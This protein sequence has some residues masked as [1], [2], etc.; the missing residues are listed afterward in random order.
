M[1]FVECFQLNDF[2]TF[3]LSLGS[4]MSALRSL[5]WGIRTVLMAAWRFAL[6]TSAATDTFS[7]PHFLT[8][9]PSSASTRTC[10]F[11]PSGASHTGGEHRERPKT[12][13]VPYKNCDRQELD[14]KNRCKSSRLMSLTSSSSKQLVSGVPSRTGLY[15]TFQ[16]VEVT[17]VQRP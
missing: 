13:H 12:G 10:S 11:E 3:R 1:N 17:M 8:H 7:G 5:I 2:S 15:V 9:S 4:S 6:Q 14:C 16:A